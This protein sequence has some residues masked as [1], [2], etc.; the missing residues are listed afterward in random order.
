[1][2]Q[3][4]PTRTEEVRRFLGFTGS[5]RASTGM[6]GDA[7]GCTDSTGRPGGTRWNHRVSRRR[8]TDRLEQCT[9]DGLMFV[10]FLDG[11]CSGFA[12]RRGH[13]PGVCPGPRVWLSAAPPRRAWR[14]G[15]W[16][17]GSGCATCWWEKR[18]QPRTGRGPDAGPRDDI[19]RN[20][21]GPG[22]GRGAG[23]AVSHHTL[24]PD[25]RSPRLRQPCA[26]NGERSVTRHSLESHGCPSFHMGRSNRQHF[27]PLAERL[28]MER[29]ELELLRASLEVAAGPTPTS[30]PPDAPLAPA[31]HGQ[32]GAL[33]GELAAARSRAAG[34]A[35]EVQRLEVHALQANVLSAEVAQLQRRLDDILGAPGAQQTAAADAAARSLG[36]WAPTPDPT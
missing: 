6:R 14:R 34:M 3:P 20:G 21:R 26:E 12:P 27:L 24:H 17:R 8:C 28:D 32:V 29:R 30:T 18:T 36:V 15:G 2:T 1:M 33:R 5:P 4:I 11:K 35:D 16:T 22:A 9:V 23:S 13:V 19:G 7:Q 25:Y 10:S 31:D